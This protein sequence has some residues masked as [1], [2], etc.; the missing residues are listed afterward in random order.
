M[1]EI[2]LEFGTFEDKQWTFNL[3]NFDLS[4]TTLRSE[5]R[6]ET[7][8]LV[9]S[10]VPTITGSN[11]FT[12]AINAS[13][14]GGIAPGEYKSDVLARNNT[15]FLQT[16]ITPIFTVNVVDRITQPAAVVIP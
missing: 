2:R 16:F 11:Q 10:F 7:G 3:V 4:G 8:V 5:I 1:Q 9:G 15:T 13:V 12:L 6:S 14:S